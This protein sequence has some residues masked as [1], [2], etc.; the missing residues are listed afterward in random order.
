MNRYYSV[1]IPFYG[2]KK[3]L[4]KVLCALDETKYSYKEIIFVNDG[5]TQDLTPVISKFQC[6]VIDN[7]ERRGP[8]FARNRGAAAA[9]FEYLIFLD[10]DIVVPHD[11]FIKINDFLDKNTDAAVINCLVSARCPYNDFFSRYSNIFFRYSILKAGYSAI[12]TSFCVVKS[13]FFHKVDGFD[14]SIPFSYADDVVLGWKLYE[15]GYKFGIIKNLELRHYKKVIIQKVIPYW[16]SHAY[17]MEKYFMIYN[18]VL[19]FKKPLYKKE[20]LF[21]AFSSLFFLYL[22]FHGKG[23]YLFLYLFIFLLLITGVNFDFFRALLKEGGW[24]FLAKSIIVNIVQQLI[25]FGGAAAGL[26]IGFIKK[27][28]YKIKE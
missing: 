24:L 18:K 27:K 22:F 3:I 16:F 26:I 11:C 5:S 14:E 15:K 6:G 17:Y 9:K 2:D 10:S 4:E 21:T 23:E 19:K 1:I 7:R 25:Y 28:S 8:S 20:G 13:E 12:F